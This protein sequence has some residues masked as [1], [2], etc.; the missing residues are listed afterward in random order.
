LSASHR[1]AHASAVKLRPAFSK[2]KHWFV[3]NAKAH[4]AGLLID[5]EL[6]DLSAVICLD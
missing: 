3:A 6:L 4:R 2:P 1:I 5:A